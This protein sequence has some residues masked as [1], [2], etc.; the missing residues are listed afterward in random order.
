VAIDE[1]TGVSLYFGQKDGG[2]AAALSVEDRSIVP[3][4]LAAADLNRDG[5]MDVIVGHVEAPSTIYFND[6]SGRRFTAS[7]FGDNKGTVYGF[8]IGDLNEDG[9][10]DIGVAR[11]E[12]PNVVYFGDPP[13]AEKRK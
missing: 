1:G 4:A 9:L 2:F 6:G 13:R 11:S 8:A 12:A 7:R 5:F 3:Y 10:L